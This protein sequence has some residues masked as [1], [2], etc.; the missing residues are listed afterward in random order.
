MTIIQEIRKPSG[1]K[2]PDFTTGSALSNCFKFNCIVCETE[3]ELNLGYQ[4]ENSWKG[5]TENISTEEENNA[6]IF[7][8]IGIFRRA[9]DGGLAVFDKIKCRKCKNEYLTFCSVN[10]FS[11]SAYYVIVQGIGLIEYKKNGV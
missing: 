11:N 6:K 9:I 2:N 5:K 3:L 8:R 7:Y 10:E 4:I 1:S